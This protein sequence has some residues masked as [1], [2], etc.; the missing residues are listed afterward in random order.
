[1]KNCVSENMQPLTDSFNYKSLTKLASVFYC[2]FNGEDFDVLFLILHST[3]IPTHQELYETI[4]KMTILIDGFDLQ[5]G[6]LFC[7]VSIDN[8]FILD[9]SY[10]D[11][12]SALEFYLTEKLGELGKKAHTVRSR[13]DQ[14]LTSTR[15][16]SKH[17]L[18]TINKLVKAC[19]QCTIDFVMNGLNLFSIRYC[20]LFWPTIRFT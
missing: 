6:H 19:A 1:M 18:N 5:D 9:N 20:S 12:H 4:V 7:C 14:V 13:N 17:N 8:E 10:E 16:F 3:L 11:G 2:E 15:L